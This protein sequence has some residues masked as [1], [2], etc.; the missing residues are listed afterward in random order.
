MSSMP[1]NYKPVMVVLVEPVNQEPG[2][3]Q[4]CGCTPHTVLVQV[5]CVVIDDGSRA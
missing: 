2:L 1:T 4:K 5:A 3:G